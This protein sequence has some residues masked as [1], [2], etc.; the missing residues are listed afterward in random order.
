[1]ALINVWKLAIIGQGPSGEAIVNT[2]HFGTA[3]AEVVTDPST[4]CGTATSAVWALL[5]PLVTADYTFFKAQS[6]SVHGANIGR[7][8]EDTTHA[9][10]NGS[11]AGASAPM[12]VAAICKRK[13]DGVGRHARGRIFL[14]PIAASA[15]DVDSDFLSPGTYDLQCFGLAT[16]SFVYGGFTYKSCLW[17]AVH[18]Q[19]LEVIWGGAAPQVGIQKRRRLRLPN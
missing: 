4:F 8:G 18:N 10:E 19:A 14:S 3:D 9:A 7:S 17:D 1:M 5:A 13:A 11:M 16:V 15:M 2:F 6:L 12:A